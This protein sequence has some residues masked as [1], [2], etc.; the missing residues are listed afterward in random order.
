MREKRGVPGLAAVGV[1][2]LAL[3]TCPMRGQTTGSIVG[4]VVD[5]TGAALPGATVEATSERLQGARTAVTD[6][7]GAYRLPAVPPGAYRVRAT[8]PGFRPAE[9]AATVSIDATATVDLKLSPSTEESVLVSGETPMVDT[10]STT[11]GTSYSGQL[12]ASLPVGR[13]YASIVRLNPGVSSDLGKTQGRVLALTIDGSTSAENL[14]LIEGINTTDVVYGTQGKL[15]SEEF[16][17]EIQ[18]KTG[19]YQAE[20]GG[21]IGG[22]INVVTKQ[23]GNTFHGGAF[24]FYDSGATRAQPVPYTA[25]VDSSRNDVLATPDNNFDVGVDL[26]GFLVKDRVWFYGLYD[27]VDTPSTITNRLDPADPAA[28]PL[29]TTTSLYGGKL[30]INV[31]SSTTLVGNVFSD[32]TQ[33]SG[34]A[35]G[36]PISSSDPGTWQCERSYGGLDAALRLDHLFGARVFAALQAS[37]HR[38]SFGLDATGAGAA[39][40]YIDGRARGELR[41][42]PA[43]ARIPPQVSGGLGYIEG[44]TD[45]ASAKRYQYGG[46]AT[47]YAGNHEIKAGGEYQDVKQAALNFYTGG[48]AVYLRNEYGQDYFR[49][50]FFARSRADLTPVVAPQQPNGQRLGFYGQDAWRVTPNLTLNAGLRWEQQR[51]RDTDGTTVL[52]TSNEWQPRFGVVWDPWNDGRTRAYASVGR[53]Y[54]ALPLSFAR[55]FGFPTINASTFNFDPLDTAQAPGVINHPDP[56]LVGSDYSTPVD[57]GLKGIYQDELTIGFERAL[58]PTLSVGIKGTFRSLGR[59][60]EDR[61]DLD[62]NGQQRQQLRHHESGFLGPLRARRHAHLQRPR[63]PLQRLLPDR[64]RDG[65]R[66]A[67]LPRDRGPRPGNRRRATLRPG[68]VRVFLPPR[69]LRGARQPVR[70]DQSWDPH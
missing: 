6:R 49:H 47:F 48:Q 45:N 36:D 11:A 44:S 54:N 58:T 20:Y 9:M 66:Q 42:S 39:I 1:C 61:C 22:V 27:R 3:A 35:C 12:Y 29:D 68:L 43:L 65:G 13:N 70:T 67:D 30:T 15:L 64:R 51:F 38:D 32:P 37:Q 14:W 50:D 63:R 53:F 40:Q 5:V 34:A 23:G 33:A 31:S 60:I 10:T 18:V 56:L 69:Q 21:A 24:V 55:S 28:F 26:G 7:G 62:P 57:A 8:I 59:T 17:Q 19:G 2:A 46:N 16:V 4:R 52:E 25:G 41:T